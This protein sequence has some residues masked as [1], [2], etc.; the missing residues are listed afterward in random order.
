MKKKIIISIALMAVV[1]TGCTKVAELENGEDIV[2]SIDGLDITAND[3]YDELK[4][5]GGVSVLVSMI[6]EYIANNEIETNDDITAYADSVLEQTK[7]QYESS[8]QDFS[9]ALIANGFKNEDEYKEVIIVDYK[10]QLIVEQYLS[11]ELTEDELKDYYDNEIF[12]S[13]TAKHILIMPDVSDDAS[14]EE[15]EAANKKAKEEAEDLIKQL[16]DGAD[17]SELAEKYSDDTGTAADGGLFSD[18]TKDQVVEEFWN[19]TINLKDDEYSST[20][21]QSDYGYHVILRVSQ[22]DKPSYEDSL[23]TIKS[24]LVSVKLNEDASLGEL[25]WDKIR[26]EKYNLKFEDTTLKDDYKSVIEEVEKASN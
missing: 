9:A 26:T 10:K 21:V 4:S 24:S 3:L 1:L 11:D 18:F 22:E 5:T 12:G 8:G 17:F 14:E 7:S 19:G 23:D 13:M 15:V 6:D 16:D 20:P 2:V 25:I